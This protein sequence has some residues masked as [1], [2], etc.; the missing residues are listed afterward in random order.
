MGTMINAGVTVIWL[1]PYHPQANP[2]GKYPVRVI[3]LFCL[4][5]R[6][7]GVVSG[8]LT[9]CVSLLKPENMLGWVKNEMKWR[10]D[11]L[12]ISDVEGICK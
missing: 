4:T 7:E 1:A 3:F 10:R 8:S 2:I 5:Y 12:E 11:F 6:L 9:E